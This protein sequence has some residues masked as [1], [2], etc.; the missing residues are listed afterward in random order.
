MTE[1]KILENFLRRKAHRLG[2][3]LH[4]SRVKEIHLNNFGEFMIV[5]LENNSLVAGE[6]F[7]YT[8]EDVKN[9][10]DEYEKD[11]AKNQSR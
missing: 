1:E 5:T 7:D 11:I 3:A 9:F 6:K 2:L 8:L 10:L 4:K